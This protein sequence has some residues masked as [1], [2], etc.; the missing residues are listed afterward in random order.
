MAAHDPHQEHR[1]QQG[2]SLNRLAFQATLHCMTGCAIGEIAGMVIGT[3]LGWGMWETVGLAV[4]LA[5]ITGFALTMIPLIRSGMPLK[6]ALGIAVAADFVSVSVMEIVDNAVMMAIPGAMAAGPLDLFFWASIAVA[7]A[8]AFA[9]ALP[10]NLW[11][12]KRG[13]GH[14]VIHAQHGHH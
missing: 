13:K 10:I 14:A 9:V 3:A 5:F 8:I 11:L 2:Q 1:G 7:L 12:I 6:R 4:T